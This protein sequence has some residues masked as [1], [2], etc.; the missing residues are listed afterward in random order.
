MTTCTAAFEPPLSKLAAYALLSSSRA[1]CLS[2]RGSYIGVICGSTRL[3]LRTP[4]SLRES[5]GHGDLDDLP[6]NHVHLT[7]R[8]RWTRPVHEWLK[9][10][11]GEA[12][13][14]KG[15][16]HIPDRAIRIC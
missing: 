3:T 13:T 9:R 11:I 1:A 8:V 12:K 15:G 2:L 14:R 7:S 16:S 6:A 10:M 4:G 5:E